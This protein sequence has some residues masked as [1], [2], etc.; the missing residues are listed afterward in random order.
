MLIDQQTLI[1]F[2]A[3]VALSSI[4]MIALSRNTHM[5]LDLNVGK[6]FSSSL[7]VEGKRLPEKTKVNCLPGEE[8]SQPLNRDIK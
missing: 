2:F 1:Q 6:F 4:V 8:K 7:I 5:K 3:I